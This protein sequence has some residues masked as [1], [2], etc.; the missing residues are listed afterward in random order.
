MA[1]TVIDLAA[2]LRIGDG[3]AAVPEPQNGILTRLLGVADAYTDLLVPTAPDAIQEEAQI[4]LASYLYDQPSA[5]PWA[6]LRQ[7]LDQFG[8]RWPDRRIGNSS[9][10]PWPC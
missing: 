4:R 5:S 6:R 10:R 7:R 3:V 1:I 9:G 8:R 2:A